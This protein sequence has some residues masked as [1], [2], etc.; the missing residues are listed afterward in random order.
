MFNSIV[1]DVFIGL[2]LV[3]LLYS[4]LITIVGEMVATWMNLRPRILRLSIEKML[5]DGYFHDANDW[6][7]S[8]AYM[9]PWIKA[10]L[11]GAWRIIQSFFLREFKDFKYSFAGR[12]Y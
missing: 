1:L 4:L 2:V 5:N 8:P 9:L 3:Y 7:A 6:P 11:I 12:F 10:T